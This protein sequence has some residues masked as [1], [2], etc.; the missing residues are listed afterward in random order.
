MLEI[1]SAIASYGTV[2]GICA[3][4]MAL[5]TCMHFV[6]SAAP[7]GTNRADR[8]RH[9]AK[10]V[11]VCQEPS[12]DASLDVKASR[13][14][15]ILRSCNLAVLADTALNQSDGRTI[16][17]SLLG[18]IPKQQPLRPVHRKEHL[19][20]TMTG[21]CVRLAAAE[22]HARFP[23][24]GRPR[25][26]LCVRVSKVLGRTCKPAASGTIRQRL[27]REFHSHSE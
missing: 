2:S 12:Q 14:G 6:S 13:R 26:G 20:R 18:M 7:H 11:I 4:L 25:K 3:V 9:A 24:F 15:F 19:T 17:N 27:Q 8:F 22:R 16:V 5:C 21:R 23:G 10:C 1:H